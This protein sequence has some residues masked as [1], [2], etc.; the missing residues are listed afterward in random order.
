MFRKIIQSDNARSTLII[1]LMV[2]TVFLSEGIQKFLYAEKQGAGRFA[3]IGLP[4]PQFLGP[5]VGNFEIIC[6]LLILLGFLT[7]LAAVPL[8]TIM[9]VAI[10][11]TK[12]AILANG[13]FWKMLHDSRTDWAM[14]LGSIFLIIKGGGSWSLDKSLWE[15]AT[16]KTH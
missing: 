3:E 7:R 10:V 2:G 11:T 14:L 9:L 4:Y 1:R 6:G 12:T 16:N 15:K 8:L 5:F 13:G